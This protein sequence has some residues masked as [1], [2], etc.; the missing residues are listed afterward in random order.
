[1]FNFGGLP[2]GYGNIYRYYLLNLPHPDV[3]RVTC[4][5][6]IKIGS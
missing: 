2:R 5:N 6:F 1:M 3:G 4:G